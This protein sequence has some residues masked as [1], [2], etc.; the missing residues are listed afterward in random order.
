MLIKVKKSGRVISV[1]EEEGLRLIAEGL[2]T[3]VEVDPPAN[4]RENALKKGKH[5]TR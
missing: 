2:A 5:E 1:K 3:E 4:F